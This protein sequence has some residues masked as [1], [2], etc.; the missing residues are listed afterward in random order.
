MMYCYKCGSEL[1]GAKTFCGVCGVRQT[2]EARKA[3]CEPPPARE[4][5]K[6]AK[7]KEEEETGEC[8]RCGELSE[9]KCFFCD[10]YICKEHITRM[11]ANTASYIDMQHYIKHVDKIRV[12]QGWRG[13]II[14][15]CPRCSSIRHSKDLTE[16]DA[17][18][19]RTVDVCTWY[20]VDIL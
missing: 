8:Y 10:K 1:K 20:P 17:E 5:E 4:D 19:I 6:A 12:N 15:A 7:D 11:Q 14:Y 16:E 13:Y 2:D 3:V 18:K 9:R